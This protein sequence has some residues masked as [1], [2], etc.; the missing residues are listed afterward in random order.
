MMMITIMIFD[1]VAA[2]DDDDNDDYYDYDID[3]SADSIIPCQ[4]LQSKLQFFIK[5]IP[6][7]TYNR[8]GLSRTF[9]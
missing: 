3:E 4:A 8:K 7:F 1:A 6:S 2:A 9:H 5:F